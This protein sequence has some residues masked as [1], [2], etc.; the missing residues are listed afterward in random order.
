MVDDRAR[1]VT[2]KWTYPGYRRVHGKLTRL[3]H[4]LSAA[5]VRPV[6]RRKVLAGVI[7]DYHRAA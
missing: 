5:T 3:G 7:N 2:R 6:R 1:L 4:H